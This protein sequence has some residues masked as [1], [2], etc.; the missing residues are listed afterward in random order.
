M[1]LPPPIDSG[2]ADGRRQGRTRWVDEAAGVRRRATL[3]GE[4]K[5]RGGSSGLC[6]MPQAG[7]IEVVSSL[8]GKTMTHQFVEVQRPQSFTIRPKY[9]RLQ[10]P[11]GVLPPFLQFPSLYPGEEGPD[12]SREND[13]LPP[14]EAVPRRKHPLQNQSLGELSRGRE[15]GAGVPHPH[16]R[17]EPRFEKVL[18]EG[19][20]STPGNRGD[21]SCGC[22]S[23]HIPR[24]YEY[25][26]A[27]EDLNCH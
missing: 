2:G 21:T 5:T 22:T 4:R 13:R 12:S 20:R 24:A 15:H 16:V 6:W 7:L 1:A 18:M 10:E 23:P 26:V 19:P 17:N 3:L 9:I 14:G 11:G 25:R 8:E 27:S